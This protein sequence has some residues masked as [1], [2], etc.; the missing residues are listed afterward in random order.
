MKGWCTRMKHYMLPSYG[1]NG[2]LR[3]LI[4]FAVANIFMVASVLLLLLAIVMLSPS[5]HFITDI[6][7][8]RIISGSPLMYFII[9][10]IGLLIAFVLLAFMTSWLLKRPWYTVLTSRNRLDMRKIAWAFATFFSLLAAVQ[11]VDFLLHRD[12][13]SLNVNSVGLYILFAV[14]VLL[15][16]PIQTTLEEF[17][18]RGIGVQLVARFTKNPLIIALVIGIIFGGLHFANPEMSMGMLW[19]GLD[20]V[21][22]GFFLTYM[23]VKYN[24]TEYAIGAHAANNIFLY[25]FI[26]S[27]NVVGASLPSLLYVEM[28]DATFGSFFVYTLLFNIVFYMLVRMHAYKHRQSLS[29]HDVYL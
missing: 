4:F 16:V 11:L 15:L 23:S 18:Y 17:I 28:N 29:Q 27:D 9:E 21:V 5:I 19:V 10:H 12:A 22:A 24:A 6:N 2:S 20:Y 14:L 1:R 13:Y 7:D 25:L 3:L 26:T 8:T